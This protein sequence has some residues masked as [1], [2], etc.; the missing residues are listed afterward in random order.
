MLQASP[1]EVQ[2]GELGGSSSAVACRCAT[3]H[4]QLPAAVST[5]VSRFIPCS[6]R[7]MPAEGTRPHCGGLGAPAELTESTG[8][9]MEVSSLG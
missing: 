6:A 8:T 2:R 4:P 7:P 3:A 5:S 9:A 1:E